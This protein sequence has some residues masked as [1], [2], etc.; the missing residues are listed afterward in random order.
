LV[1]FAVGVRKHGADGG[2]ERT[3]CR[4]GDDDGFTTVSAAG[5]HYIFEALLCYRCLQFYKNNMN[6]CWYMYKWCV[7]TKN[8]GS[9]G[10]TSF[11]S[12]LILMP[13]RFG[14][15]R[16]VELNLV[17]N[18]SGSLIP[19][20]GESQRRNK[21]LGNSLSFLKAL[22]AWKVVWLCSH[23]MSPDC[24]RISICRFTQSASR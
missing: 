24:K 2:N 23:W 21:C 1:L 4:C 20:S 9:N 15:P 17:L 11:T 22:R 3:N 13:P 10:Q 16:S 18:A 8:Y 12:S 19:F 6:L 5:R 7:S 14:F